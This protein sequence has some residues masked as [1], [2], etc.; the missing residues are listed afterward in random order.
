MTL[1]SSSSFASVGVA[2]AVGLAALFTPLRVISSGFLPP[3]DALSHCAKVVSGKSWEDIMVRRPGIV[4]DSH[5]GWHTILSGVMHLTGWHLEALVIFS[6]VFLFAFFVLMPSFFSA[7]ADLWLLSLLASCL[8]SPMFTWRLML[9]RPFILTITVVCC[10]L[11]AFA[12]PKTAPSRKTGI[13]L[14]LL[15]ALATWSHVMWYMFV[16]VVGAVGLTCGRRQ[17]VR[18]SAW[19][20]AGVAIG[21]CAT[22]HPV[23]YLV[24]TVRHA[25]M[26]F[27]SAQISRQL[28]FELQPVLP[29]PLAPL[30]AALLLLIGQV[31]GLRAGECVRKP[32]L[33]S[34]WSGGR[35]PS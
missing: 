2:I 1:K 27:Q 21:A 8:I 14:I 25:A 7:S 12:G 3:D 20:A 24:Q 17:M 35:S 26:V 34:S 33:S 15:T 30:V 31:Q 13:G 28:V 11:F 22:G 32:R 18:V 16:L 6:V 23:I 4:L 5:P 29:D 10:Y 9:G 19:I